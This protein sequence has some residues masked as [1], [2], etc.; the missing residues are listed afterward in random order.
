MIRLAVGPIGKSRAATVAVRLADAACWLPDDPF[1]TQVPEQHDAPLA[2]RATLLDLLANRSRIPLSLASE[3][4]AWP[5]R[6]DR[7]LPRVAAAEPATV[8]CS[9]TR[10]GWCTPT[11][12]ARSGCYDL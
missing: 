3:F 1:T 10:T 9:Y 7:A 12:L 6:D 4:T 8:A 5:N 2:H 11:P